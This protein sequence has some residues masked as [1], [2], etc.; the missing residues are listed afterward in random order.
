[1][2]KILK[3]DFE[4]RSSVEIGGDDGVGLFNYANHPR[5]EPLV[6]GHKLPGEKKARLWRI[7]QGEPMPDELRQSLLDPTILIEAFNSAFERYILQFKLG[8]TIPP[9]RFV[10]PQVAARYLCLPPDLDSVCEILNLPEWLAKDKR[11]KDL[12]DLFCIPQINKKSE[13]KKGAPKEYWND[14]L[15]HP[16]EWEMFCDYCIRDVD[17]EEEVLRRAEML[18]AWPMS[19]FERQVW[20]FD[21]TVNDRG[22]PVDMKFVHSA[23]KIGK[24]AKADALAAQNK[25]TGLENANSVQQLLPWARERGYPFNT[26]NK[27]FVEAALSDP[28]HEINDLCRK[29][30]KARMSA[31]STSYT[32]LAKVINHVCPDQTIKNQFIYLGSSRCGRWSGAAV[33]LHNLPRPS[34]PKNVNGADFEDVE[35]ITKA[36]DMIYAEDY[37]GIMATYGKSSEDF[38]AVLEVIK[39]TLRTMFVAPNEGQ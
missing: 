38:G 5:T 23:Y 11:G 6:L 14:W 15:T 4:T 35:T 21:Q 16:K 20:I 10:D 33:Q 18:G 9:D 28:Q 26:L 7:I 25:L 2:N 39:S 31:G 29:V 27:A 32:K 34:H 1:M 37:E 8:I 17:A 22:M 19:D 3:I 24:R 36:R 30:L 13:V 12:I